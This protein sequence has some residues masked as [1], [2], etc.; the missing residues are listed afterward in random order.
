VFVGLAAI[1]L[2]LLTKQQGGYS[3]RRSGADRGTPATG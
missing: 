3:Y 2:G 1:G